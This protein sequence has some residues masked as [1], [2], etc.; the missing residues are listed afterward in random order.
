MN[1]PSKILIIDDEPITRDTLEALL[2]GAGYDVTLAASGPEG[3]AKA[4]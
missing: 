1:T 3:L 4:A 2:A